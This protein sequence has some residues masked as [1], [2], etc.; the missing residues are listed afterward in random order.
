MKRAAT[1]LLTLLSLLSAAPGAPTSPRRNQGD[2]CR[3]EYVRVNRCEGVT[4]VH[5]GNPNLEV[6]SFTAGDK[7]AFGGRDVVLKVRFFQREPGRLSITARELNPK[8]LYFMRA[9]QTEWSP[10]GV[11]HE[12]KPWPTGDVINRQRVSE[13]NLGVLVR[14][15]GNHLL[16]ALVYHSTL[17]ASATT[18]KMHLRTGKNFDNVELSLYGNPARNRPSH[19]TLP[20]LPPTKVNMA[21]EVR[22]DT[23]GFKEGPMR[24]VVKLVKRKGD[25]TVDEANSHTETYTFYHKPETR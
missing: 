24:L 7:E 10:A 25:R 17:P 14:G 4:A 20:P 6:L 16:P 1:L 12:F 18:Y 13:K 9:N 23:S 22:I 5:T 3:P 11:W 21:F 19:K 2:S 8:R 15:S